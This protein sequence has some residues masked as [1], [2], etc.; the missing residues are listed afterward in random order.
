MIMFT[1]S[2]IVV[3]ALR[4]HVASSRLDAIGFG[5]RCAR[6]VSSADHHP[7]AAST[8][9]L[10]HTE[11]INNSGDVDS[12]DDGTGDHHHSP[13]VL[14]LHG[15]LGNTKNLKTFARAAIQS[16]P[17]SA[18]LMDLRG[19]GKSRSPDYP[20]PNNFETVTEDVHRTL[21]HA[22]SSSSSSSLSSSSRSISSSIDSSS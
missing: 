8:G 22:T 1:S 19:H 2:A 21:L 6:F 16:T 3:P 7:T 12:N 14:F 4:K 13:P 9:P 17:S 11:V 20:K 10:L 18:M 15:L 5:R